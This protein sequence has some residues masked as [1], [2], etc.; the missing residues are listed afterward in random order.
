[1][2]CYGCLWLRMQ[3]VITANGLA[4]V[5]PFNMYCQS[6]SSLTAFNLCGSVETHRL[7]S[8]NT[9]MGTLY[10]RQMHI[11]H[12]KA[13]LPQSPLNHASCLSFRALKGC[14]AHQVSPFRPN[15]HSLQNANTPC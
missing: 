3:Y 9:V 11:F 14:V 12:T 1:V 5:Q 13:M 8:T 15:N 4:E 2:S 7:P 10:S 6:V